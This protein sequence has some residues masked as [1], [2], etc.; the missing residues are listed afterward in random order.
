MRWKVKDHDN[1]DLREYVFRWLAAEGDSNRAKAT[2][3]ELHRNRVMILLRA[4]HG[5]RRDPAALRPEGDEAPSDRD[6]GL[7][8][9]INPPG[10]LK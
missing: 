3:L 4:L 9:V 7:S 6:D 8:V 1:R 5:E 10:P 2:A